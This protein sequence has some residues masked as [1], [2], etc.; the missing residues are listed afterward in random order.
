MR[1]ATANDDAE[2]NN[3]VCAVVECRLRNE[4]QLK[5]AGTPYDAELST[6]LRQRPLGTGNE[7]VANYVVPEP[8][9]DGYSEARASYGDL[10]RSLS[11]HFVATFFSGVSLV[12]DAPPG[13]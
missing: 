8:G 11:T 4:G 13:S 5:R 3:G 1:R 6:H 2:G 10:G 7:A 12:S 9:N